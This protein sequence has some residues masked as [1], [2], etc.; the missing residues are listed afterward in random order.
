[1]KSYSRADRVSAL[2]QRNL[3]DILYKEINDPRFEMVV[4]TGVKVSSDIKTARIYYSAPDDEQTKKN[5]AKGFDS[6]AGYI[7][8]LLAPRLELR[9]MPELK[10]FYDE[11]F[12]YGQRINKLIQSLHEDHGEDNTTPENE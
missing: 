5:A 11:S 1:M 2:I 7:K 9:Y 4:I 8:K 12:D 6:A 3:S 10:F